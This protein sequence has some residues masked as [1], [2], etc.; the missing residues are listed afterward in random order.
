MA[1]RISGGRVGQVVRRTLLAVNPNTSAISL[2]AN[3]P[4][5]RK[6]TLGLGRSLLRIN[7]PPESFRYK[8]DCVFQS[9]P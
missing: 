6:R 8:A 3:G 7:R 2:P 1:M 9:L 5:G 4:G